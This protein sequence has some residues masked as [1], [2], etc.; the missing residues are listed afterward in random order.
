MSNDRSEQILNT[1]SGVEFILTCL[2]QDG[3]LLGLRMDI[4]SS[5]PPLCILAQRRKSCGE[6]KVA[7]INQRVFSVY[8]LRMEINLYLIRTFVKFHVY[9]NVVRSVHT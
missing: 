4:L 7:I 8:Y 6:N 2:Y 3:K 5:R 1:R 9:L